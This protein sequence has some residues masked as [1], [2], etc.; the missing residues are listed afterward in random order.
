MKTKVALLLVIGCALAFPVSSFAKE[1]K[2]KQLKRSDIPAAIQKAAE[3]EA[4]GG[5]IVRWEKEGTNYEVVIEKGGKQWGF[6]FDSTGKMLSKH[7]ESK[8]QGEKQEH[9]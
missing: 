8:E 7:D 5:K 6:V 4:A 2:E 9:R 3:K 1:E